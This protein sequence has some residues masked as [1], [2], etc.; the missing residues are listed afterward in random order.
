MALR[1]A[2][3]AAA[4]IAGT[5]GVLSLQDTPEDLANDVT[6]YSDRYVAQLSGTERL[7]VEASLD[8][9][10]KQLTDSTLSTPLCLGALIGFSDSIGRFEEDELSCLR[11]RWQVLN[12]QEPTSASAC[13]QARR[14]IVFNKF[15]DLV[16]N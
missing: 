14:Q 6:E 4:G 7:I 9:A 1:Y 13:F 16:N 3:A 10:C 2:L 11:D 8:I 12:Q 15:W 5:I